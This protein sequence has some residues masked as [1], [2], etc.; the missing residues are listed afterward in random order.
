MPIEDVVESGKM[1][2]IRFACSPSGRLL[3]KDFLETVEQRDKK[4]VMALFQRMAD[5]GEDGVANEQ[6]FKH[7]EG[8]IWAFKRGQIRIPCF[9]V[10]NCWFLTHGFK[11]KTDKWPQSQLERAET[12]RTHHLKGKQ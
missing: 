1:R 11:K 10:E 6:H 12:I 3:A 2:T 9:R 7:E 4:K 8:E 5:Y